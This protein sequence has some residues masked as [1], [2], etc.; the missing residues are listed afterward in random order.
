MMPVVSTFTFQGGY[1]MTNFS[2]LKKGISIKASPLADLPIENN[3]KPRPAC[4]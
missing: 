1:F 2:L 4:I 3:I